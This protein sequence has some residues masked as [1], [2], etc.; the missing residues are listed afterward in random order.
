MNKREVME[1]KKRFKKDDCTFTR[2]SGCYVSGEKHII[3]NFNRTFL[4][5][6]EDEYFKYLEIAKKV[7]SG[8][9]GN[10]LL[11]LEFPG[12]E[13][14]VGGRQHS[15][16]A[17][18]R[19]A[20]KDEA[21]LDSFY[22]TI[23][24]SY[25]YAGNYL[26]VLF[27]DV[28]DVM[29]K[30]SDNSKLDES[31][32]VFEYV[33][34]AICPVELSKPGLSYFEDDNRIGARVRD[35]IV[36]APV[37]GFLFPAFTDR[38]AD[39]H[40]V[41]YYTKNAKDP[42]PE[43]MEEGLGC[44]SRQTATEQKETFT[45]IVRTAVG[46]DEKQTEK[47]LMEIQENINNLIDEHNTCHDKDSEPAVLTNEKITGILTKAGL[48][49]EISDKIEKSYTE[50]FGDMPPVAEHLIDS[51]ALAA[52]EQKKK[53]QHLVQQ[54]QILQDKLE[55]T[56]TEAQENMEVA[57]ANVEN[58][59]SIQEEVDSENEEENTPAVN[60]DVV[61]K[62][63]PQKLPEIKSQVIDGKKCIVIPMDEDEQANVN[64]VNTVL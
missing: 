16:M 55:K 22:Q 23:I 61:V 51:K 59:V 49:E 41:M 13:E 53:E 47:V 10:N 57:A 26:I 29:T 8:T 31:E 33:L 60:Y 18:K 62:V 3:L 46:G 27:H 6:D 54:V 50:K 40:S 35:W 11:E 21:L 42:H 19:S 7:L 1:L 4:N 37:N 5:L 58:G 52:N 34:C 2:M 25:D 9:V 64:G 48:P 32:E 30:T 63:K 39:I 28:Y 38:S 12:L 44:K 15:L 56:T 45:N 14:A 36:D 17:L 24:D 43:F 20:L